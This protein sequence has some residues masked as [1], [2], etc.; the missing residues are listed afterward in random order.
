MNRSVASATFFVK[1]INDHMQT[2]R[3]DIKEIEDTIIMWLLL[4]IVE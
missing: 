3:G 1:M 4:L 2:I